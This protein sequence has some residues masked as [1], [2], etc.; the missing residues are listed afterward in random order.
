[1]LDTWLERWR[2]GRIGWHEAEGSALLKRYW[3]RLV[4]DSRVLVPFCGKTVDL[5]WLAS[6]G[7]AVTGVEISE[8]AVKAFFEENDLGFDIETGGCLP[9][10]AAT[11]APVRIYC[12][13]YFDF[14]AAPFHSLYDRGSLVALPPHARPDYAAKTRSLLDDDAFRLVITLTYDE[15]RVQGPPYSI[16]A[17]ELLSYWPDLTCVYSHDDVDGGPPKFREAGLE[18]LTE[19]VWSSA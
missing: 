12:G 7:L 1:M 6:Q 8:I 2:E 13:D 15:S 11:T 9:C 16:A 19:S 4:R 5:L 18:S 10:Y 17:E 14:D 3:P